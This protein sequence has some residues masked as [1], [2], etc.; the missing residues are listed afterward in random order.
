MLLHPLQTRTPRVLFHLFN[1]CLPRAEENTE[2]SIKNL[3]REREACNR[4][5]DETQVVMRP[6]CVLK[7]NQQWKG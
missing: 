5:W 2:K 1:I 6:S 4:K 3:D 7:D